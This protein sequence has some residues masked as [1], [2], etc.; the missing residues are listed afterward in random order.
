MYTKQFDEPPRMWQPAPLLS[1]SRAFPFMPPFLQLVGLSSTI[2][3]HFSSPAVLSHF[4]LC[5]PPVASAPRACSPV[6]PCSL[7]PLSAVCSS[8]TRSLPPHF[9]PSDTD[10]FHSCCSFLFCYCLAIFAHRYCWTFFHSALRSSCPRLSCSLSGDFSL[11]NRCSLTVRTRFSL[12]RTVF[13]AL[14]LCSLPCLDSAS[15]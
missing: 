9:H 10:P 1:P 2:V 13:L 3:G 12:S 5:V 11:F 7:L 6:R 8:F 15:F 14:C 4:R